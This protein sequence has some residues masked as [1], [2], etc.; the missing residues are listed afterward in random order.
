MVLSDGNFLDIIKCLM[1]NGEA[2]VNQNDDDKYELTAH[3]H[4]LNDI[5]KCSVKQEKQGS[6][7]KNNNK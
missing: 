7:E 6:N 2:N 1:E 4:Y 5:A 3:G